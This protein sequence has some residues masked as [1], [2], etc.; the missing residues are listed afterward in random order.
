[1]S[2]AINAT[3]GQGKVLAECYAATYESEAA[4]EERLRKWLGGVL[5]RYDE[6]SPVL[7]PKF[8]VILGNYTQSPGMSLWGH[9]EVDFRYFLD[10]Q[11]N[12]I[13]NDPVFS[14]IGCTGVWGSHRAE[15][16]VHRWTFM[17]MRHYFVEGRRDMLSPKYGFRY[18]SGHTVNGDFERGL[19]SWKAAGAVT[20]GRVKKLGLTSEGRR[21]GSG[22]CGDT[23]AVLKRGKDVVST[24]SQRVVGLVPGKAYC[25]R[26]AVLDAKAAAAEVRG[27][28][29]EYPLWA[30]LPDGFDVCGGLSWSHVDAG[31]GQHGPRANMRHVVF[32]A[33]AAEMDL[34]FT[35]AS[36]SPGD[37]LALNCVS[38]HPYLPRPDFELKK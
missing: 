20:T 38:V 22:A 28:P 7:R 21:C 3:E 27:E 17:L 24:V 23:F 12:L 36:A 25:L 34:V 35:T 11:F 5:A 10:M 15:E 2:A 16:E 6:Y 31:D 26:Y 1:M 37:E 32:T 4:A 9:P 14:G 30:V 8:G 19:E 18:M 33:R 29:R 13:A